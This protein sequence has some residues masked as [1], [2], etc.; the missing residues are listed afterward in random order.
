MTARFLQPWRQRQ[1]GILHRQHV[2]YR[3]LRGDHRVAG[4]FA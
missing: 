3:G 4:G 2:D 1:P